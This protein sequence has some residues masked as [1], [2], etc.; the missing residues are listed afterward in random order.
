MEGPRK[1]FRI[2][3]AALAFGAL[4]LILATMFYA[5]AVVDQQALQA[6][7]A[8]PRMIDPE[9]TT[10]TVGSTAASPAASDPMPVTQET[11][12]GQITPMPDPM[13]N[14]EQKVHRKAHHGSK[15]HGKRSA[16]GQHGDAH[17]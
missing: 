16:R 2:V 10:E 12:T 3:T 4:G 9:T 11:A 17:P 6:F 13:P 7:K 5:F 15:T 1:R 14:T 8:P